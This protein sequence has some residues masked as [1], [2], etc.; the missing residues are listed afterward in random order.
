M[1]GNLNGNMSRRAYIE[2][3]LEAVVKPWL[4]AGKYFCLGRRCYFWAWIRQGE[5][6]IARNQETERGLKYYFNCPHL[7]PNLPPRAADLLIS[8][9]GGTKGVK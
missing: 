9:M 3:I 8:Q 5:N 6:N 4:E 1:P 7:H 2:T